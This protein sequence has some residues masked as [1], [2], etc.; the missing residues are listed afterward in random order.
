M[1]VL[2]LFLIVMEISWIQSQP[3]KL[4]LFLA[5]EDPPLPNRKLRNSPVTPELDAP[6]EGLIMLIQVRPPEDE[7]GVGFPELEESLSLLLLCGEESDKVRKALDS[8][9]DNNKKVSI[10]FEAEI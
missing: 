4:S 10:H 2:L 8:T 3:M 9:K 7:V 5:M 1:S 6:A